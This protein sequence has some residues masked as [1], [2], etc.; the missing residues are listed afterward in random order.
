MFIYNVWDQ[1]VCIYPEMSP[2]GEDCARRKVYKYIS[3]HTLPTLHQ[4]NDQHPVGLLAQLVEHWNGIA[5]V[6]GSN[7]IQA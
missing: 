4:H 5:E 1:I 3:T 7:P 6:M 2:V